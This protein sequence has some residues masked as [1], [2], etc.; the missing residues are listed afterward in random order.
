MRWV[1]RRGGDGLDLALGR[2]GRFRARVAV[3]D[4]VVVWQVR[5]RVGVVR[6]REVLLQLGHSSDVWAGMRAAEM[7]ANAWR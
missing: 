7:V 2:A 5:V 4:G 6:R 1:A 3:V